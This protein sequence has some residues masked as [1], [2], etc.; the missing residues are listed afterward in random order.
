MSVLIKGMN[1]PSSCA[2]CEWSRS[3]KMDLG[4]SCVCLMAKKSGSMDA[5]RKGRLSFCP[6]IEV[7]QHGR[8]ID[9]DELLVELG[10][11]HIHGIE[12]IIKAN[13]GK[14]CWTSGLHT[15]W[16]C[17][18]DAPTIIEAEEEI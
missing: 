7:P 16:R 1:L 17:I 9:A 18:D 3:S 6:L 10:S 15:A 13:D 5:A 14:D 2:N 12:A 4:L 11:E 8:L